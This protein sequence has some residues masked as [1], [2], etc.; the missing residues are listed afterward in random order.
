[1]ALFGPTDPT[2][3]APLGTVEIVRHCRSTT[4]E[5][6]E[7]RACQDPDC[8]EKIRLHEVLEAIDL[9]HDPHVR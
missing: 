2:S 1:V 5:Q 7:I 9:L 8:M 3:W 6:G 4:P